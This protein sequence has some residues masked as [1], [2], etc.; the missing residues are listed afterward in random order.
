MATCSVTCSGPRAG[1]HPLRPVAYRL[2]ARGDGN[3][4]A[5]LCLPF[6]YIRRSGGIATVVVGYSSRRLSV[7]G[8]G[9]RLF[10]LSIEIN[11]L[12]GAG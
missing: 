12:A 4:H 7:R 11:E 6:I 5:I 1:R 9:N 2:G 10:F 3:V 8:A